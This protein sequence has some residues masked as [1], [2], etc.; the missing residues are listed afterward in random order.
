MGR[1]KK[2]WLLKDVI[3]VGNKA[4]K[5]IIRILQLYNPIVYSKD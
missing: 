2:I 5:E 4:E 1:K 3:E